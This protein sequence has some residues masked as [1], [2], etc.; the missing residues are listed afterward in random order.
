MIGKKSLLLPNISLTSLRSDDEND[1]DDYWFQVLELCC[2]K[3]P[4]HFGI[5]FPSTSFQNF[6]YLDS[7][8]YSHVIKAI[9][10][11]YNYTPIV[12]KIIKVVQKATL[13][14]LNALS[15]N[16]F[17]QYSDVYQEIV[18]T[19]V[20]S[21]LH[22]LTCDAHGYE[23]QTHCFPRI[24]CTKIVHGEIPNYFLIR[25]YDE[26]EM[27]IKPVER[28][29]DL[30]GVPREHLAI[31]MKYCGD[32]LWQLFKHRY[33]ITSAGATVGLTPCQL[34]GI[35]Y[36]VTLALAVAECVY[37]FEHR[38]LHVCN[39]LVKKTKKETITF[40][41]RSVSYNVKSFGVKVCL[42][43]ATFSRICLGDKVYFTDLTNR[44]KATAST[45]NP[46]SQEEAYKLMYNKVVDKWRDWFP[47][48]NIYW[49]KYFYNEV[50]NSEA[51]RA[52]DT[53]HTTRKGLQNLIDT[54]S[55]YQTL[56]GFVET[57]FRTP[58]SASNPATTSTNTSAHHN[59]H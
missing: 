9:G 56:R 29:E 15:F 43:D 26:N 22:N 16:G 31:L 8:T 58:L 39:V 34:L 40:V 5:E 50:Y 52:A 6:E 1:D 48:T 20:L 37:Q 32:S 21:D 14:K 42:I 18:I 54:I 13:N 19:K 12:F 4:S 17:E 45:P 51:F 30:H 35:C 49:C 44:L 36:Q 46:D 3:N 23:Y 25:K 10:I 33:R 41:I 57:M 55:D 38:D 11:E 7:G 59:S 24:Y 2:Q 53:N 28:F 47:E 27:K